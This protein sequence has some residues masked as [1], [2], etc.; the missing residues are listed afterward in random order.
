MTATE[1]EPTLHH[2]RRL[3]VTG[4]VQ[5]VGFRPF[6]ARLAR[7]LGLGGFVGNDASGVF[8]EV[9]GCPDHLDRFA[10]RLAADAPPLA[11]VG[12][13]R[14]TSVDALGESGFTIVESVDAAGARTAIP[15]DVAVCPSCVH[16]VLDPADRRYRY[17]FA[18]CT[19]CGPR[20]TIIR[21]LPYDRPATTMAGFP[22]C[23]VCR[24]EYDDPT[25]RRFHAQPVACPA[26]GPRLVWR[27]TGPSGAG[28]EL[29]GTD[30]VLSACF[31][32]LADRRVVAIKGVGGFHLACSATDDR[33][34]ALLRHRKGRGDKP[35]A[36]MVPD[37]DAA[38]AL[39]FVDDVEAGAL[40][41]PQRPIV[42]L[43]RRPDA[44][45]SASVAPGTPLLG[46][47]LPY[48]PLHHLLFRPVPGS[49]APVPT[50]IVLTSGNRSNEPICIDDDEALARLVDLADAFVLHDRP[51]HVPCDDSVVRVIDGE[52]QPVRRSRGWA[53]LPID[54]PVDVAPVLAVGGEL[55]NTC[56]IASG[57]RAFVSQHVGDMENLETLE[58]FGRTVEGFERMYAIAPT[59]VGVDG[60]PGYLT[61]RWAH[62]HRPQP[63]VEVQHHHAHVAAVM[64]EHGLDGTEP[65]IGIAFDGTG[66]GIGDDGAPELWGGEVLLADYGGFRRLGHLRPLPL[67]GGDAAVRNPCRTAVAYLCA[68]GIDRE[69]WI[70][71]VAACDEVE[72]GVVERQ[73]ERSLG[74]SPT[75]SMGRLFDA[76]ASLLG[77]RHRIGYEAQAA[78]ELEVLA[79]THTGPTPAFAFDIDDH[80]VIDPEPAVRGAIE[81][82]RGGGAPSAAAL[83]LHR[84]IA[85][86]VEWSVA[87]AVAV[88]GE[89]PVA[90][91]GGVFQNALLARLVRER[92]AGR[93]VLVHRR[94]PPNDG[95]LSLGQAVIAGLAILDRTQNREGS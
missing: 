54:L 5:G 82:L 73:V 47:M 63:I 37:L 4:V 55:K 86:A 45:V 1:C 91:T 15:P 22:M 25:D 26:C 41:S 74:T 27:R 64:A 46:V 89:R 95:G 77:V 92:L 13:V 42:L 76:M 51:I 23:P 68:M 75:T 8:V 3:V 10:T 17:P 50:A 53:P 57:R 29:T 65:V 84:A 62:E 56:C 69:P 16:E 43:R 34:V 67:P 71:A 52:V 70:P 9:E 28:V 79:A 18:N 12:E 72:L 38:R 36:V 78:I 19:D 61:R 81:W 31:R 83:A 59:R 60:H 88:H 30:G 44:G 2:R 87:R 48:S 21:D 58:A 85:D 94:V 66:F 93:T 39:A 33:A 14:S 80:G 32:A 11:V 20:F 90:L 6:V 24:A 40:V 35:F 49:D 7:E